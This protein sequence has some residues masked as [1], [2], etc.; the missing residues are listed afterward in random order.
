MRKTINPK[1]KKFDIYNTIKENYHTIR[2]GNFLHYATFLPSAK[3]PDWRE[4]GFI[5]NE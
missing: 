2:S 5:W 4:K 3:D 1:S